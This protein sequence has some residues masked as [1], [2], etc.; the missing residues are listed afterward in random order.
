MFNSSV[1]ILL[2][3]ILTSTVADDH[4]TVVK[5]P[6]YFASNGQVYFGPAREHSSLT[7]WFVSK[8]GSC[9]AATESV[10]QF[11]CHRS[12]RSQTKITSDQASSKDA[13]V[14]RLPE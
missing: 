3:V 14:P 13:T 10:N 1:D 7:K 12:A 6:P 8:I 11:T 5:R 2:Y 9:M 4:Q